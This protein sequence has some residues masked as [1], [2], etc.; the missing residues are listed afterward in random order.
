[1]GSLR[2][3]GGTRTVMQRREDTDNYVKRREKTRDGR[4][5]ETRRGAVAVIA[6]IAVTTRSAGLRDNGITSAGTRQIHC[7]SLQFSRLPRVPKVQLKL[8]Q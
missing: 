1:M 3:L 7:N 8:L 4:R 6:V 5:D 2:F